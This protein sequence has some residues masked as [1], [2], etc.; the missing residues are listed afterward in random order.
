MSSFVFNNFKKEFLEGKVPKENVWTFIPVGSDFKQTY[1]KENVL[2]EQYRN[3]ADFNSVSPIFDHKLK[4]NLITYTWNKVED[5]EDFSNKPMFVNNNNIKK[6]KSTKEI[7]SLLSDNAHIDEYLEKGGFYLISTKDE[8]TWF[9]DRTN[10]GNNKIIGVMIDGIEGIINSV[11]GEK[12]SYPFEGIFDGNGF[13]F[14]RATIICNKEN[15]GIIGVLGKNGIVR[16]VGVGNSVNA[17]GNGNV[18]LICQKRINLRH[19][20]QSGCDINAGILIGK[21]FGTVENIK[22]KVDLNLSGFVPEVYSV[23]NKSDNY[24]DFSTPRK[25]YGNKGEN[26]F[27]L[28]SFC[29]DSPGNICPYVGYFNRGLYGENIY[30]FKDTSFTVQDLNYENGGLS[31]KYVQVGNPG[32]EPF[33]YY[34]VGGSFFYTSENGGGL[35]YQDIKNGFYTNPLNPTLNANLS[36]DITGTRYW[37]VDDFGDFTSEF[38]HNSINNET[39]D[40]T[41]EDGNHVYNYSTVP[42]G[43][44]A[45]SEGP[46]SFINYNWNITLNQLKGIPDNNYK[47]E[48]LYWSNREFLFNYY[49][50]TEFNKGNLVMTCPDFMSNVFYEDEQHRTL[51]NPF[52]IN[53]R[54]YNGCFRLPEISRA[55][56]NVGTLVGMNMGTI[57]NV[58]LRNSKNNSTNFVGFIGSIAG[59]QDRGTVSSIQ[60]INS[61]FFNSIWYRNAPKEKNNFYNV[62]YKRTPFIHKAAITRCHKNDLESKFDGNK[63]FSAFFIEHEENDD[64]ISYNLKPIFNAGGLFGK[65]TISNSKEYQDVTTLN[66]IE[67]SNSVTYTTSADEIIYSHLTSGD[68]NIFDNYGN[69][70][71]IL[72]GKIED[73]NNIE[74]LKNNINASTIRCS[75]SITFNDTFKNGASI[76]NTQKFFSKD[77]PLIDFVSLEYNT[78]SNLKRISERSM[79][80][81][82]YF[83][84]NNDL[85]KPTSVPEYPFTKEN[86]DY[87]IGPETMFQYAID[88]PMLYSYTNSAEKPGFSNFN[89]LVSAE[90]NDVISFQPDIMSYNDDKLKYTSASASINYIFNQSY[91]K[92]DSLV[93]NNF[94]KETIFSNNKMYKTQYFENLGNLTNLLENENNEDRKIMEK[95]Y[96]Y[97]YAPENIVNQWYD[98]R[99]EPLVTRDKNGKRIIGWNKSEISLNNIQ[100]LNTN[101]IHNKEKDVLLNRE[102]FVNKEKDN[103]RFFYY[104]YS[105][106]EVH[107]DLF[108][109][110]ISNITFTPAEENVEQRMGYR[111]LNEAS[112]INGISLTADLSNEETTLKECICLG[113]S[114]NPN[115]IRS[116]LIELNKS[117]DEQNSF[118]TSAISSTNGFGGILVMDSADN[119]VMFIDNEEA[120]ELTGNSWIYKPQKIKLNDGTSAGL[121]LEVE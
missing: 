85:Y 36:P 63:N 21:N 65:L 27:Y 116:I 102:I 46:Y 66:N 60:V 40:K 87:R 42:Y 64:L 43:K 33:G 70:A 19:I 48:S 12:E 117:N 89:G 31:S 37:G 53:R 113:Q 16:N 30:H 20:K 88:I 35:Y 110:K 5:D 75:G 56:Y 26:Y 79:S 101:P 61:D 13:Y 107:K 77:L 98:R 78:N 6:L 2:L 3:I 73:I 7:W 109:F 99:Q 55:E 91:E 84:G 44:P 58:C 96:Q 94:N 100:N 76:I 72:E 41:D 115:T 68:N 81:S 95:N 29:I 9:A 121:L 59:L 4:G 14:N 112:E 23:T 106:E 82:E 93:M 10:N 49:V 52:Y 104:S 62:Y 28:N 90:F 45:A 71:A 17:V 86:K 54:V 32:G 92:A 22:G 114:V 80:N 67:I 57:R 15:N 120:V 74:N 39:E 83:D 97:F 105:K 69:I 118:T 111:F 51:M 119:C 18:D 11:I 108:D 34:R 24:E 25:K 50:K 38:I 47:G 8:L 1:E 103:D